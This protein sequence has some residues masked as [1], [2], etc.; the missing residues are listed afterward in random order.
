MTMLVLIASAENIALEKTY[1]RYGRSDMLERVKMAIGLAVEARWPGVLIGRMKAIQRALQQGGEG[2]A[3]KRNMFVHGVHSIG[4]TSGEFSLTMV[5]W[6]KSKRASIVTISDAYLVANRISQLVSE[7]DSINGAYGAWRFK[8]K[9]ETNRRQDIA[10]A[11]THARI[12]RAHN[13]KRA[14][15]LLWA[16][17]RP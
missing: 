6:P 14:L 2:L 9:D 10:Q 16:N 17:L 12:V 3:E 11:K 5:R 7:A 15:K 4:E 13:I 8:V 1:S